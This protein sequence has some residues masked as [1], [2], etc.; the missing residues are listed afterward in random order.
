MSKIY[1]FYVF[2]FKRDKLIFNLR[3]AISDFPSIAAEVAQ[4]NPANRKIPINFIFD[5]LIIQF[6]QLTNLLS[7]NKVEA[8]GS[9]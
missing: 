2:Q 3:V 9:N 6:Q 4:I 1:K 5:Y 7:D 8:N